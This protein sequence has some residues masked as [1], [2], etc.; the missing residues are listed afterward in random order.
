MSRKITKEV[1]LQ[2]FYNAFPEAKIEVIEYD[3][4]KKPCIIKCAKCGKIYRKPRAESFLGAWTCCGKIDGKI[5]RV[6]EIYKEN[7]DFEI[8]KQAKNPRNWVVRHKICGCEMERSAQAMLANPFACSAC[9]TISKNQQLPFE[10][11]SKQIEEVFLGNIELLEYNGTDNKHNKYRCRNCGLIFEHSQYDLMTKCRGCP[12]CDARRSKGEKSMRRWLDER[13]VKYKEQYRFPDLDRLSFDFAI[14]D[15][16]GTVRALIEI[17]GEQHYREVFK[18]KER[19][20]GFQRQLENDNK[21]R[22]YCK[23][24]NIPLYE[25]INNSGKLLNLD[26]ITL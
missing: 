19:P 6:I 20:N 13:K 15:D 1:F 22:E 4:L 8:V 23:K 16:V 9:N 24:N 21:K 3:S 18:Y 14:F 12:K 7:G 2:R 10:E 5:N 25:I 26:I 17:Q 11:A